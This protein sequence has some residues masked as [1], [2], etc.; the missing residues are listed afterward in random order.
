M[1]KLLKKE[2][3][4]YKEKY[5]GTNGIKRV[6]C[7]LDDNCVR[8]IKFVN[9]TRIGIKEYENNEKEICLKS[10]TNWLNR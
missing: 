10:A 8:Y 9:N 4:I 5:E 3:K 1:K 7:L 2:D 6:I